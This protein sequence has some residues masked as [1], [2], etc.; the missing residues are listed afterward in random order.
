MIYIT[1]VPAHLRFYVTRRVSAWLGRDAG[2][3]E[4]IPILL[5]VSLCD[6]AVAASFIVSLVPEGEDILDRAQLHLE[7]RLGREAARNAIE[8]VY[9]AVTNKPMVYFDRLLLTSME[10]AVA[11]VFGTNKD[12]VET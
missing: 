7:E 5:L 10:A 2:L 12:T 1:D 9:Y 11:S 4:K 6:S 8:R 3:K